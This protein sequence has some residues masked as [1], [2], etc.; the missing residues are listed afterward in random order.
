MWGVSMGFWAIKI[1]SKP[2]CHQPASWTNARCFENLRNVF[3]L[4]NACAPRFI[5]SPRVLHLLPCEGMGVHGRGP[6]T[7]QPLVHLFR[8]RCS[9]QNHVSSQKMENRVRDSPRLVAAEEWISENPSPLTGI[10]GFSP[11]RGLALQ[12]K[13]QSV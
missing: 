5:C 7:G 2:S 6:R 10:V 13:T 1:T 4:K 3:G 12:M 8:P 9:P 11:W